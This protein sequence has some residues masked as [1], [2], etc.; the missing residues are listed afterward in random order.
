MTD[1]LDSKLVEI[2]DKTIGALGDTKDFMVQE[3]PDVV[4]QLLMW[5]GIYNF[6]M[7][8]VGATLLIFMIWTFKFLIPTKDKGGRYVETWVYDHN[9]DFETSV[10]FYGVHLITL[11]AITNTMNL[12]WL[13]ILIAPKIWLIEYVATLAK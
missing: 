6:I 2:L 10:L 8:I 4:S 13:K 12:T 11:I 9:G 7:F 5:Y 1:E 3:L